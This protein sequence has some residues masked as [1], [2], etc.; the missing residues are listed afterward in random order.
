MSGENLCY[1]DCMTKKERLI[2]VLSGLGALGVFIFFSFLVHKNHFT[3][4]D[5]NN[6]V[7]LQDHLSLKFITPFSFLSDIG[8]AE[9]VSVLLL[10]ILAIYRRLRTFLVFVFFV[11]LHLIEIYGKTFVSHVPPPH[12]MLRTHDIFNLSPFY[13][14]TENS[15]P[16][17]HTGRAFFVT[18]LLG[19]IAV[20]AKKLSHTQKVTLLIVLACYD[21]IMGISR[22][23]LGEHWTSDVIGGSLLGL[24]CGLFASIFL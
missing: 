8:T 13:V 1:D 16:S 22:I 14:R 24:A 23:Y 2:L 19:I 15:Y 10:I 11:V 5:F 6:T 9:I 12:F 21:I 7:R 17:G 3:Q 20:R 4:F 18:T